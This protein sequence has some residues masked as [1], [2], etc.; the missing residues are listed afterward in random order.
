MGEFRVH[1]AASIGA[2]NKYLCT[3]FSSAAALQSAWASVVAD[4]R[5][6]MAGRRGSRRLVYA[7]ERQDQWRRRKGPD[8]TSSAF[9]NPLVTRQ[10]GNP[11]FERFEVGWVS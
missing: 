10:P 7:H 4:A 3:H 1:A 5:A 9:G 2:Q 6:S 8:A 11:E